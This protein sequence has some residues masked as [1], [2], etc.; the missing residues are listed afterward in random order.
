MNAAVVGATRLELKVDREAPTQSKAMEGI[1]ALAAR[2]GLGRT[3]SGRVERRR[4]IGWH[5]LACAAVRE[6]G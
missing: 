4:A 1:S 5:D 6:K 2:A 3:M